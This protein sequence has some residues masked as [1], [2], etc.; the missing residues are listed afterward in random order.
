MGYISKAVYAKK[1]VFRFFEFNATS[2]N[3]LYPLRDLKLAQQIDH[4]FYSPLSPMIS[5]CNHCKLSVLYS[6]FLG[7]WVI[8]ISS[9]PHFTIKGKHNV[10]SYTG[11][12]SRQHHYRTQ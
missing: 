4:A 7:S 2:I 12:Q 1:T 6:A 11:N 3:G 10:Y 9:G 5:F 8:L